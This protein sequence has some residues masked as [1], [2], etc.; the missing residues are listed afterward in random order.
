MANS[1]L[2][3][4]TRIFETSGGSGGG[5]D[6][7]DKARITVLENNEYKVAYFAEIS[8]SSGTIT[9]PTNST[10]LLDQ[11]QSGL[12]ALVSTEVSGQPTQDS[13]VTAGG[14]V[15]SVT[16]FDA[17]GN[18]TLSG[19]PSSYPVCL[20]Y[21][22]KIKAV[23]WSNL[24]ISNIIEFEKTNNSFLDNE[25]EIRDNVDQTKKVQFQVSG[26]TTSTTRT[27]SF[28][29]LTSTL[30]VTANKLS[31]F[32]ATTSSE[33][34]GVISDETG[35][36]A[37]V[38]GTTPTFTT[39]IT[40]PLVIGGT[41]TTST[42]IIRSTSG[43]GTTGA[44]IIFQTG[45]N[46]ATE[47]ARILNAG[48]LI[49]GGTTLISSELFS[50]QKNQ[51][52]GTLAYIS[53]TTSNTGSFTGLTLSGAGAGSGSLN[54]YNFSAGFTTTLYHTQSGG[55][56]EQS[57][58]GGLS[59][60]TSNA[61]GAIRFYTGGSTERARITT[62]GNFLLGGITSAT[63]TNGLLEINKSVTDTLQAIV[64][65]A[66]AANGAYAQYQA[67][68]GTTLVNIGMVGTNTTTSGGYVLGEAYNLTTS[69]GYSF[70]STHASGVIRFYSG[71]ANTL[72]LNTADLTFANAINIVFN[73]STGTKLGTATS[74]KIGVWNATPIIQ[75]TTGVAA[76]T[77]VANTSLI[78]N[79]TATFDGY[80]IGQVVKA[81][82]NIGLL[83]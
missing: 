22:L 82:R 21:I 19:T 76:A 12:D 14:T 5:T 37:L 13:P 59:I 1:L 52:A 34:A 27:L 66:S 41:G 83:A 33:L 24:T 35:S 78:A 64:K 31:V 58:V 40:S 43:V 60:V 28:P 75:P 25:L 36:G 73:T 32:A 48:N 29:D 4:K 65:N 18:Y 38:F 62:A 49:V 55:T 63:L 9:T 81:L 70:G 74:Q 57:G 23:D 26:L 67:S 11:F 3:N 51:N 16:S 50:I 53:N 2:K 17:S 45:N 72:T 80:T 61:S 42:A 8:A 10:I 68:N 77:F 79:D 30:A 44:D 46:G 6:P 47:A 56:L 15:V 54:F 20:I 39:N 7:A 69:T 71:N